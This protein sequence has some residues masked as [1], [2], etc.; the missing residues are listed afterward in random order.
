MTDINNN[1]GY[2]SPNERNEN[3]E[4]KNY[5]EASSFDELE[6][7]PHILRGIYAMGFEYP[8]AIQRLAIRP[9]LDK[10]DLIAQAQSGTGKTATF[11]IGALQKVDKQLKKPQVIVLCPNRELAQQIYYNLEG[12]NQYYKIQIALIMGGTLV[13]DNFKILDSGAQFIIGTPGRV[14]DMMKRYVLKTTDVK[15]FV[16][17]EADEML[18]KGFKDQIYEIFQFIPKEAQ[19]CIFSATLPP[20]ALELTEK[21]MKSPNKILVKTDEITLEGIKQY[22]LGV[23]HENW[24]TATLFDLYDNLSMKQTIIFCNS[25]RKAE[26]LKEQ[27]TAENFTVS[28][29]HSDLTQVV[30]DKTM[31]SFRLGTSRILIATDVIARGIDIQQVEIVINFDLP[32]EI[33]TYIHRIGRSGRF[34]RKGIAINFVTQKEYSQMQRIEQHYHTEITP[35]PENIKELIS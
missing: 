35:L 30:R 15:C 12:L 16:M 31:K 24:K 20:P 21:F 34:G 7:N 6:I 33:E 19:I 13:D 27:L 32:R 25:K 23:Q 18:S 4:K 22:Y 10:H 5:P 29:I 11:L 14:Y 1:D 8:S 28:C 3:E 2:H 26:W 9:M 17:D